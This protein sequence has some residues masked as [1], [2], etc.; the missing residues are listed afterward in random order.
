MSK[1]FRDITAAMGGVFQAAALVEQ[2]A[3]T[4]YIP[5]QP[6]EACINTLFVQNPESTL[7]VYGDNLTNIEH[8]LKVMADLLHHHQNREYPDTLRYVLG[9]LHI[10]KKLSSNK[11]MQALI[12]QRLQQANHQAEHF[13]VT[14]DNVIANL[15]SIYTDTL[16]SFRFRI[17]V[18]GDFTYLQ[19]ERIAAQV[20]ALL[21]SGVRSA[22]LWRQVGGTR[23]QMI[24]SRKKLALTADN[25]LRS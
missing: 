11:D 6:F 4:G 2:L 12:G 18:V 7:G 16:S 3:K 24:L 15:A 13:G 10:Q 17:Q 8:G 20:R 19:Q 22:T 1:D 5:S 23:L 25:L 21:F 9:I 14:H